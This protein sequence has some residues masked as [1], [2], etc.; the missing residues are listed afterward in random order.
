MLKRANVIGA[1][2]GI[3]ASLVQALAGEGYQ[4]SAVAR[5][6]EKLADVCAAAASMGH[7]ATPYV[8]DVR[9]TEQAAELFETICKNMDGLDLVVYAAGVMPRIGEEDYDIAV[10]RQIVEVNVI[11]A[12]AWLN[13]A[14]KRFRIQGSGTIV[15]IGSVAGDRGRRGNPAY[16]SSK[17]ALHTYLEALRNRLSQ[18]GVSVVTIK[19]GPVRTPMTDGLEKL[20]MIID[21]DDAA[22][23]IV[24]AIRR[25]ATSAYIPIQWMPIMTVIRAIPS[26]VFRRMSF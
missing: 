11:G 10:D 3:G 22:K 9:E 2:S 6:E 12:M 7:G 17:A 5:R 1:S 8:H 16:C 4:V 23:G 14:A 15:G 24:K 19:P 21:A 18:H 13:L 25:G 26:I 20:P